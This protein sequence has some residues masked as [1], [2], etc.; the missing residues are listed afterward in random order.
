[1]PANSSIP[2]HK[3]LLHYT[4]HQREPHDPWVVFV[5][6]AGGS[7][8]I[9]YRQLRAFTLEFNVLMVDL[10]GHGGSANLVQAVRNNSYTFEDLSREIL[11]VM[12]D[13][14]VEKAHFVGIS[15]GTILIRTIGEVAPERLESMIL[16]GAVTRLNFRSRF[17]VGM[18][19]FFKRIVPYLWLYKLFAWIIMPK[20]RHRK[21]RRL[22]IREAHK[23]CQTEFVRWFRLT[24][25]VNPLLRF[26]EEKEIEVPTL[27]L[28]GD[29]DH[30]FLP[31]VRALVAR[32]QFSTLEVIENSGHVCNV[33]QPLVFN[34]LAIAFIKDV[35]ARYSPGRKPLQL[36]PRKAS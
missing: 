3:P 12:D 5:H 33:E 30:M 14:G 29:E 35:A 6:G 15:L 36:A 22:F 10:R 9:W 8:T 28:M 19:N 17:L 26:F 18:G 2:P 21:A 32:H 27:Y 16:G 25:E 7:S 20:K 23:L 13:A 1:V 31:P 24:Y 11:D 34:D 4:V